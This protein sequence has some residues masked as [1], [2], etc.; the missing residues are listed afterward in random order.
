M[1]IDG[2]SRLR[3]DLETICYENDHL[4]ILKWIASSSLLIYSLGIPTL[5]LIILM[6]NHKNLETYSVKRVYGFL[7]NGYKKGF[8]EYWEI[9]IIYRKVI[10]IFIQIFLVQRGKITQALFTLTFLIISIVFLKSLEPYSKSYL[11]TLEIISLLTSAV[12]VFF[13]I[14]FISN[15]MASLFEGSSFYL[16]KNIGLHLF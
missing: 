1:E 9:I 7:Y 2:V 8:S 16:G 15:H 3:L 12:S 10:F 5:G 4:F 13:G 11:N 6:R 14:I